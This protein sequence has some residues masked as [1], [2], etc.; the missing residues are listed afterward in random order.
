MTENILSPE[1]LAMLPGLKPMDKYTLFRETYPEFIYKSFEIAENEET[2]RLTF[3]FSVPGLA[4]FAP[5]WTLPKPDK[6]VCG[7]ESGVFRRLVFSLGLVELC[8]YWKI[9]CPKVVRVQCGRISEEQA[10]W[11]KQQYLSGLG[12]FFYRN[13]IPTDFDSFMTIESSGEDFTGPAAE[14][15]PLHGCLIPVGG[16]KDSIVTLTLLQDM[17]EDS[18]CYVMNSRGATDNSAL[19]AGYSRE[20]IIGIKRTL[21][22]NML[23]LNKLG[24]LNGHTPF[25][26]LVAF[27]GVLMAAL[28][29]KEYVV[30]SNESSAN[31]STVQGSDVNH[32]YSKSFQFEADFD[33][34]QQDYIGSGV[35]YFSL[36]RPWSEFQIA[37]YFSGLTD[38]HPVFRSCNAGSKTDS[39]CGKCAKCLF[40]ALILTPFLSDE[41]IHAIFGREILE[42]EELIPLLCELSG[43]M[44]EKPFECVGSRD[45]ICTAMMLG[46]R[47]RKENGERVPNLLQ[48]FEAT[49]L[50]EQTVARGNS[51]FD[52]YQEENLL[53]DEFDML[54]R[55]ATMELQARWKEILG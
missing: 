31:E 44:P 11:W 2:I 13:G 52:Y 20:Q 33:R 23:D 14:Q 28:Y 40:V 43:I 32:Q 35:K 17:R 9:A 5:Q 7:P 21:D 29:G 47:T 1:Q 38:F 4:D 41:D 45:E 19:T 37:A 46:I 6:M 15:Y 49:A 16:G 30:L 8:S 12:E 48:Y 55:T 24:Y 39:W 26:A 10:D 36:L 3:H 54:M 18:L 22:K 53:P 27:S 42:D 25:S 34:Y 50:Y 51:Y